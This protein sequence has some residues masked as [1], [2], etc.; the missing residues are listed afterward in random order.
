MSLFGKLFGRGGKNPSRPKPPATIPAYDNLGREFQIPRKRWRTEILPEAIGLRWL[1]P[2]RLFGVLAEAVDHGFGADLVTAAKHLYEIDSDAERGGCLYGIVLMEKGDLRE[3]ERIFTEALQKRPRS[4]PLLT[5]LA[6]MHYR[7]GNQRLTDDTLWRALNADPNDE[8]ALLWYAAIERERGGDAGYTAALK[9][10]AGIRG[11]WRANL[12]LAREHLAAKELEKALALYEEVLVVAADQPGVLTQISG[13]LGNSGFLAE[14]IRLVLPFYDPKRHELVA[15]GN[16][17]QACLELGDVERGETLLHE[18]MLIARPGERER[19]LW[20]SARFVELTAQPPVPEPQGDLAIE[21]LQLDQPIWTSGLGDVDWLMP[22]RTPSTRDIAVLPFSVNVDHGGLLREGEVLVGR[23]GRNGRCSRALALHLTDVVRFRT[24]AAPATLLSVT[25]IGMAVSGVEWGADTVKQTCTGKFS[26]A[27]TGHLSP[28]G[29]S[30]TVRLS[31]WNVGDAQPLGQLEASP[32]R[33]EAAL[34]DFL[35]A[36]KIAAPREPPAMFR[37][38]VQFDAYLNGLGQLFALGLSRWKK[39]EVYG[40][41]NIHRWMLNL[42]CDNDPSPVARIGFIAALANSRRRGS[43]VYRESEN[44]ALTLFA[45]VTPAEP[46]LY[47]FTPAVFRLF[48]RMNELERRRN[49]LM[50][51]ADDRYIRWLA[52]LDTLF[53]P[54]TNP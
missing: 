31:I 3:A 35:I 12:W 18:M 21:M 23:E 46:D 5:N 9:R 41:R 10:I 40:E 53:D 1:D 48:D 38:P 15:G 16:V 54:A 34:L 14:I 50:P 27:I 4:G 25:G 6:K 45:S 44:E 29:E 17:L 51:S 2:Q 8:N 13:D 22:P 24:D 30:F 37:I 49:E 42:A 33:C 52:S 36:E 11:S 20:Y 19:L 47:R 26:H 28:R 7:R 39:S 43:E 32:D